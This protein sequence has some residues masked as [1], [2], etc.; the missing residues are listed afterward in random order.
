VGNVGNNMNNLNNLNNINNLNNMN[1]MTNMN[2][3]NLQSQPK[4]SNYPSI[5]SFL[6]DVQTVNPTSCYYNTNN[7]N[8][9]QYIPNDGYNFN[10]VYQSN[11]G[12]EY[13]NSKYSNINDKQKSK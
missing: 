13:I 6:N 8:H 3:M 2:Y 10:N 9:N 7:L 1:N 11:S 5:Y 4:L 12:N